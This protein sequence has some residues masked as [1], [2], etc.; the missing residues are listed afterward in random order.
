MSDVMDAPVPV[1][2]AQ[3]KRVQGERIVL[4]ENARSVWT[5]FVPEDHT[6]E[7]CLHP[8]YLWHKH[9]SMRV[10]Q[11]VELVH[12]LHKF[13]I[14]LLIARIDQDTQSIQSR[15][16]A[17]L[18]WRKEALPTVDLSGARVEKMGADQW[19]VVLGNSILTR[20]HETK[21]AAQQWLDDRRM[22]LGS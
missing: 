6:P 15:V 9:P 14:E 11:K 18:D 8:G 1:A 20:G 4:A 19:R 12:E 7:D 5:V 3:I 22:R 17:L 13:Y 10:G 16:I 2:Q 21:A